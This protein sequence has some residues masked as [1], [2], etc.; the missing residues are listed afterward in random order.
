MSEPSGWAQLFSLPSTAPT[1]LPSRTRKLSVISPAPTVRI[2]VP[3][4]SAGP[5][6]ASPR[7]TRQYGV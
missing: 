7:T 4:G 5:T 3:D 6:Q 1:S 2:S